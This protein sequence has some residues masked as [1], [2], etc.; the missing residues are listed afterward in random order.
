MSRSWFGDEHGLKWFRENEVIRYPR[1]VEEA[2][3]GPFIDARVPIYLEHFL[4]RGEELSKVITQMGLDWDFSYN[5]PLS[6]CL[7]C[8]SYEAVKKGDYD[9]I[10]VHYKFPYV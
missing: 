2:Y 5:K 3:S 10:A 1:D 7:P 9:L 4:Q 6:D 8:P